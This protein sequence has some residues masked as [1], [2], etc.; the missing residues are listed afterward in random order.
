MLYLWNI[1][2]ILSPLTSEVVSKMQDLISI[3]A[4]LCATSG[5]LYVSY[6]YNLVQQAS[7]L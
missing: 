2:L 7:I 4:Q 5:A 3:L 1:N 6:R